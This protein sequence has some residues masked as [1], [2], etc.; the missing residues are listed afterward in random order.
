MLSRRRFVRRL[1]LA[2][3]LAAAPDWCGS[4]LAGFWESPGRS[5]QVTRLWPL[6]DTKTALENF[7]AAEKLD[8]RN[9]QTQFS[10][11]PPRT[12]DW[13]NASENGAAA[14]AGRRLR[15]FG[16]AARTGVD[17]GQS[18]SRLDGGSRTASRSIA[19]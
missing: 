17:P 18:A 9:A 1:V 12:G 19:G 5:G 14:A 11:G 4:E 6:G 10:A 8:P 2:C 16:P 15:V 7:L 3:L 13:V